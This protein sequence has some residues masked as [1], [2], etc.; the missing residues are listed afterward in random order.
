M[1]FHLSI[2]ARNPRHVAQVLA[3]FWRGEAF[4][5]PPVA[6]GSWIAVAGDERGT[7]IEV[8]PLGTVLREAEG[9]ADSFGEATQQNGYTATHA[10]L[11]TPLSQAEV[12]AI[13]SREG[14]PAKYRKRGGTFGVI[15]LWIEGRQMVELLTEEMQAEYLASATIDNFRAMMRGMSGDG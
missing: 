3:E 7:A 5:F 15:E 13:A 14:W 9:D 4:P 12:M 11:A 6:Q 2:A 8:Y 1:L 10:A